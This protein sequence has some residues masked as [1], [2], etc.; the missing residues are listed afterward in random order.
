MSD[1]VFLHPNENGNQLKLRKHLHLV[2]KLQQ[3][4]VCSTKMEGSNL[5]VK[6]VSKRFEIV[7][8]FP[9]STQIFKLDESD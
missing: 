5:I 1:I 9:N 4:Q 2:C 3:I 8:H 6:Q 7:I